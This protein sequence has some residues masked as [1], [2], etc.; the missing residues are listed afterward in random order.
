MAGK[1][2]QLAQLNR[3]E[4]SLVKVVH[5]DEFK[6]IRDKAEAIRGYAQTAGLGLESQNLA[7]EVKIRAERGGGELL[8][9]D[10]ELGNRTE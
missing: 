9:D 5:I 3:L 8:R 2:T 7:A 4:A 10:P 1:P 6:D